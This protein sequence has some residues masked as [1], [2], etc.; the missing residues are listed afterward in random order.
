VKNPALCIAF[1]F[2]L[3]SAPFLNMAHGGVRPRTAFDKDSA[4]ADDH[5][6]SVVIGPRV[7][8]SPQEQ[9]AESWE[10]ARFRQL[11]CDTAYIMPMFQTQRANTTSGIA[12]GIKRGATDRIIVLGGHTD[13]VY[14]EV[15]GAND[16]GSG[17]ASVLE[18]ARVLCEQ[19][20]QSTIVFCCWGGEE[21][22]L[23]GSHYFT[24]HFARMN[25]VQLM[26]QIDMASGLG[27]LEMDPE[28]HNV[29]APRWLTSATVEEF[30]KLG[31]TG[32][33]YATHFY[34]MNYAGTGGS[35]S[36]H[37]D[38]LLKGIPAIDFTTDVNTPIHTPRDNW[39]NFEPDGMQR[40][41]DLVMKLFDRFDGGVPSRTV[42]R[43]WL[44]LIWG[45]PV[46]ISIP[47][48]EGFYALCLIL[49]IIA[50]IAARGRRLT[51]APDA[52]AVVPGK[53]TFT[54]VKIFGY[55]IFVVACGWFASFDAGILKGLRHPWMSDISLYEI[56]SL[57]ACLFGLW[58]VVWH[59]KYARLRKCPYR[60]YCAAIAWLLI[61]FALLTWWGLKIGLYL[62][63]GIA[64]L[65]GAMLSRNRFIKL[66]FAL[67]APLPMIRLIFSEWD[68]LLIRSMGNQIALSGSSTLVVFEFVMPLF[69][70]LVFLPYAFG[71]A[72]VVCDSDGISAAFA[73]YR[74][75]AYGY[76]LAVI[77]VVFTIW[78]S[79]RPSYNRYWYKDA[80]VTESVDLDKH[81]HDAVLTGSEYLE[82]CTIRNGGIDTVI[83]SRTGSVSLPLRD[84]FD[85]TWLNV[86]RGI[87]Q[88]SSDSSTHFD[89][90]VQ[91]QSK[92]RPY[93]VRA[94]YRS[95]RR[96][97]LSFSSDK[98]YRDISGRKQFDWVSYP[99]SNLVIPASFTVAAGD[100]VIED[101]EVTY[102]RLAYPVDVKR[103]ETYVV[104]RTV[105][106]SRRLYAAPTSAQPTH[107]VK[108]QKSI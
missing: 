72:A 14:P 28:A 46:M 104:P 65:G 99:D 93:L 77:F 103:E 41:G 62:A 87:G 64:L 43:Y 2:L 108:P 20:H 30:N 96:G 33:R 101:I 17:A 44:Y 83:G 107:A 74:R 7:M 6:L 68:G 38:F 84:G 50:L 5:Y 95:Q 76:A 69:F 97:F 24:N 32:L 59:S 102:D 47:L 78:L 92:F 35:G 18:L 55:S 48:L 11:G 88:T 3:F 37:E 70:A 40:S 51:E 73:S 27:V 91:L 85:T 86:S 81:T 56:Q 66:F 36:D 15:P 61:E 94:T 52:G 4:V 89:V 19:P 98:M 42:D 58:A 1:A 90:R 13:S 100:T 22:G 63:L 54:G 39:E 75:F 60:L 71:L 21:Q 10:V 106:Y 67:A 82:G 80:E 23:E 53:V 31:Y 34:S 8:G 49:G 25:D 9:R 105:Y 45:T 12:V 57:V 79:L 16:D 29:N 26:L